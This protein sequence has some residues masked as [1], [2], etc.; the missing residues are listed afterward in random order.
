MP[1][2]RDEAGNIWEVDA[3][4]N[5]IALVS[6]GQAPQGPPANPA[7][8]YEGQKAQADI[9]N[10]QSTI[11]DRR[12]DNA[13]MDRA[14]GRQQAT[15][16]FDVRRAE[17][18]ARIAEAA[19]A[20]TRA[21][22]V[23][24]TAASR[25]AAFK[26]YEDTVLLDKAIQEIEAAYKKGPGA[27]SGVW[28][29]R[30]FFGGENNRIFDS[31]GNSTRA[32]VK[33]V[34][35]F[36]GQENNTPRESEMNFGP[37]IPQSSDW[38]GDI[39]A[40]IERLKRLRDSGFDRAERALGGLPDAQGNI[41][42][43]QQQ[44]DP[45]DSG[46]TPFNRAQIAPEAAPEAAGYGATTASKPVP[47]AMQQEHKAWVQNW[48]QQPDASVADY[49]A[50]RA[51]LDKRHGGES[52]PSASKQYADGILKALGTGQGNIPLTIP[53]GKRE[54]SAMEKLR[55][56]I[57]SS[58]AGS[59]GIGFADAV[60]MGGVTAL[61]PDQMNA[62]SEE[63][64]G[65]MMLGQM[66]GAILGTGA[67]GAIGRNTIGRAAPKLL[68]GGAKSKVARNVATD[69]AYGAGYGGI[70]EGDPLTGATFAA[71]GSLGG[72][73][74]AKGLGTVAGGID[75]D[76]AVKFLRDKEIPLTTGQTL[77]GVAKGIEDKATS[78][79]FVGDIINARRM[80][81][82][83]A[84][85][86]QAFG[87]AGAPIGYTSQNIGK[88]GLDN[89][90][91]AVGQ[92]YN[93]ALAGAQV[94]FDRTTLGDLQSITQRALPL[95]KDKRR[96]LGQIM[97]YRV[98]P[99]AD[100]GGMT[101]DSYQGALQG[102]KKARA[103][104]PQQFGGFEDAYQDRISETIDALDGTMIR[105]GGSD[106]VEGL[107]NSNSANRMF[108]T[109][110][111]AAG[112]AKGGSQSGETFTF[113]PSQLQTAGTATKRKFPGARPFEDLADNAQQV[114]P[115]RIPDSGTAG[116]G[117][118]MAIGATALGGAG[119]SDAYAGTDILNG[120]NATLAALLALGGT[121]RGQAG[122]NAILA[123]ERPEL[124]KQAALALRK[125]KGLFGSASVPLAL[126][127]Q[128]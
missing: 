39:E 86:R 4:G 31:A 55:N 48:M 35:Q 15:L 93:D 3:Q 68:G 14:D 29:A 96:A 42:P 1:Q 127:F 88:E 106:V 89:L 105:G 100:A 11:A 26:G 98:Q 67:I 125:R 25:S 33:G 104:P 80:E 124:V 9:A 45:R 49:L 122:I 47:D 23:K 83:D 97:D 44:A 81:G 6:Q 92:S 43:V 114:L 66:G 84:F 82:L 58:R 5:P 103:K 54:L 62:V 95:P 37:Y 120:R 109:L 30:D 22:G 87:E 40:K 78:F 61:A 121:K 16:P 51:D 102:L 56:D 115:S 126:Q 24:Q 69:A 99:L 41:T 17:A 90:G 113:T 123:G 8:Q 10:V 19:A 108:K 70:T 52:D 7:F 94:P 74:A 85:N 63:N 128:D 101:G 71:A 60:G 34:L 13:R 46:I 119:A 118:Q 2:A 21:D 107:A 36:T 110:E 117:I 77:G 57:A 112:R 111:D 50:F 18:E 28:G 73:A 72:Q 64:P 79:P 38:D 20:N 116:R 53:A 65:S 75:L 27:T 76:P 12:A 91:D 59:A 32:L